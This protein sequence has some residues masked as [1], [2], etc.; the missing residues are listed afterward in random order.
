MKRRICGIFAFLVVS[1]IFLCSCARMDYTDE[2]P[3]LSSDT[4]AEEAWCFTD[5]LGHEVELTSPKRV[6]S[7]YGSFAETWILAGGTLLATTQDAVEERGLELGE[8]VEIIGTVKNP[9][10]ERIVALDPDF[11]I[12]SAD[13][14]AHVQLE[15]LLDDMQIPHA[16]F[17]VDTYQDYLF[18][19]DGFCTLT[20]R[21]DLYEEYGKSVEDEIQR[22]LEKI[23]AESPAP[24]VLLIRAYASG[25]KAKGMDNLAGVI[26]DDLHADNI[27]QHHESLLE[28]LSLEAIV[29]EDPDFIF[30]SAMGSSEEAM[31]ALKE[32]L[33]D[34]PAWNGLHAVQ[35]EHFILLPKELFHYKPNAK[36]AES[37]AYL[38]QLLYPDA[39][40]EE[41]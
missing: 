7:L 35:N 25:A 3:L 29:E 33:M 14:A 10:T 36:W 37:Y 6:I 38:A 30:V 27:V 34:N 13:I 11:V 20:G 12:L 16:Y 17:R 28:E 40:N 1:A 8:S 31:K 21:P 9:D 2:E 22:I 41:K 15:A 26:L 24:M 5:A 23:P 19:L 32:N 18:M 39:M 4:D